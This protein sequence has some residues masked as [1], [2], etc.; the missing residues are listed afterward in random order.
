[1]ML[2]TK[3]LIPHYHQPKLHME[4]QIRSGVWKSGD[5][6]SP[7]SGGDDQTSR[8]GLT[9]ENLDGAYKTFGLLSY[10]S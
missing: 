10:C 7:E 3:T 6:V 2:D 5:Q 9:S 4:A 8:T 1:M